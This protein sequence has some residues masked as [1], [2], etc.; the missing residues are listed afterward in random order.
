MCGREGEYSQCSLTSVSV[1]FL[2]CGLQLPLL[3]GLPFPLL[4][5]RIKQAQEISIRVWMFAVDLNLL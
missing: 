4:E 3:P 1:C 5:T 2:L